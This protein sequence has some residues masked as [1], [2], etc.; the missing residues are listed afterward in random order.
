MRARFVLL[1]G[2]VLSALVLSGCFGVDHSPDGKQLVAVD[3]DQLVTTNLE[4]GERTPV[5]NSQR[6]GMPSWSPDGQFIAFL[7][8]DEPNE[9]RVFDTRSGRTRTL[10]RGIAGPIAWREDGRRIAAVQQMEDGTKQLLLL[11]VTEGGVTLRVRLNLAQISPLMVWLPGTDNVAFLA[12]QKAGTGSGDVYAVEYGEVNRLSSTGDVIGMSLD[13]RGTRLTW[14][15][16]SKNARYILFSIYAFDLAK[17]TVARLPFPDR[18][19]TINPNPR[20]GPISVDIAFRS[21]D[22]KWIAFVAREEAAKGGE[23]P[24]T[25]YVVSADGRN[26]YVALRRSGDAL[27]WAVWSRDSAR[28]TVQAIDSAGRAIVTMSAN[29]TGRR[30]LQNVK[31]G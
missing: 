1:A 21:P 3:A 20:S 12:A 14:V 17:R 4:S 23:K 16:K 25:C 18:V 28:L 15:R 26:S 19:S 6:C 5:P 13:N 11:N 7:Q 29:G 10:A 22:G 2:V 24:T 27:V 30:V 9:L 31:A 8:T